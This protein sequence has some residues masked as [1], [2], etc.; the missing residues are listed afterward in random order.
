MKAFPWQNAMAFGLGTLR[1]SPEQFWAM[2]PRELEAAFVAIN[3]TGERVD[4]MNRRDFDRLMSAFPD[5]EKQI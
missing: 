4:P 1:L 3:Q 5:K 2:T